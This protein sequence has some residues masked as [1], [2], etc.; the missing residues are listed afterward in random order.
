MNVSQGFTSDCLLHAPD[1]LF[2]LLAIVFKDW[3]YHGT[4]TQTVLSYAFV[5]LVKGQ[6]DPGKTDSYRAIASSSLLL[7]LFELCILKVWGDQ[8]HSFV[9]SM[10]AAPAR[11][12]G[13]S[14]SSVPAP[15]LLLLCLIVAKHLT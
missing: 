4:V 8:L 13:W 3:L 5:P 15:S 14:S 7:K 9:S 1:L 11:Q 2:Q 10:D 12:P 6:K